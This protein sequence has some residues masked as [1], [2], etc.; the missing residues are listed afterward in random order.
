MKR[1]SLP[2]PLSTCVQ[3]CLLRRSGPALARS[4][5]WMPLWAR[6]AREGEESGDSGKPARVIKV[7]KVTESGGNSRALKAIKVHSGLPGLPGFYIQLLT[8]GLSGLSGT[9]LASVRTVVHLP[10]HHRPASWLASPAPP[11][12]PSLVALPPAGGPGLP[13]V[14][15]ASLRRRLPARETVPAITRS[16]RRRLRLSACRRL[17]SVPQWETTRARS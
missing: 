4:F 13:R 9:G 16:P 14:V 1:V 5:A 6:V 3:N 12:S 8:S 11:S 10:A 2:G 15:Q 17:L 7:T